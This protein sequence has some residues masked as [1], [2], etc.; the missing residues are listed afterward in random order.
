MT[1]ICTVIVLG[2]AM[3]GDDGAAL[4]AAKHLEAAAI[5]D[6]RIW[7]VGQLGPDDLVAALAEGP[8]VVLDAVRGVPPGEVVELPLASVA[9]AGGPQPAFSHALPPGVIVRLAAALGAQPRDRDVPR[10]RRG[11]GSGSVMPSARRPDGAWPATNARSRGGSRRSEV[12]RVSDT[13]GTR[14]CTVDNE[15]LVEIDGRNR[16]VANLVVPDLRVG[17]EVLIGLGNVLTRITDAEAAAAREL[18][19]AAL[20]EETEPLTATTS[21]GTSSRRS[22]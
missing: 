17:D 9:D 5:P 18:I 22:T 8:C 14:P 1:Q 4:L 2:D 6:C 13:A 10:D 21:I 11:N 12:R 7:R 15:V 19:D 3:R 16:L 20:E